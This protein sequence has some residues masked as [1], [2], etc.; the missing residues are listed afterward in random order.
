MCIKYYATLHHKDG[1]PCQPAASFEAYSMDEIKRN[2]APYGNAWYM[3]SRRWVGA[4]G[5][6]EL[7]RCDNDSIA[8][9]WS[10]VEKEVQ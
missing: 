7:W 6:R 3:S 8:I 9:V 4:T 10:Q 1:D 2:L 5:D